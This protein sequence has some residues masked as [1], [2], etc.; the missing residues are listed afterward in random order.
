MTGVV[1]ETGDIRDPGL[2]KL[3]EAH[4]V[5]TVVHLAA[6]VT[7]GPESSRDEEYAVDVLPP[8]ELETVD[9]R[10]EALGDL[11]GMGRGPDTVHQPAN[12]GVGCD[13]LPQ[14][15][16]LAAPE[17]VVAAVGQDDLDHPFGIG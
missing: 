5:D 16:C 4:G 7:P 9:Q 3:F 14:A 10:V 15:I 17:P 12:G 2:A 11:I 6:V 8:N 1:Y 13:R